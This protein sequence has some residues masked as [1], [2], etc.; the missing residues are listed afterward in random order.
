M[1]G[2]VLVL[3][4]SGKFGCHAAEAFWDRGWLVSQYDRR[5]GDLRSA[6]AKADVIVNG[7]NPPYNAWK[8]DVPAFTDDVIAAAKTSGATVIIPGNIYGYGAGAPEILASDTPKVAR[9]PLGRIR[10]D[11]ERAYRVAGVKTI[12]LRA[13]NFIDTEPSGSWFDKVIVAG[14]AKGQIVAPGPFD[15]PQ[16]W[17][18]LP[19]LATV[20]VDLAERRHR[21]AAFQEVL[22]PGYT[23]T[24]DE[25]RRLLQSVTRRELRLK[26]MNWLPIHL[27]RPFWPL[28]NGL[29]EM[30]YLWSMTHRIDDADMRA[31]LPEFRSTDPL[32]ALTRAIRH[33]D[34]NPRPIGVA[35]HA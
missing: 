4:A 17:A 3:G 19:D 29:L 23:L 5:T 6:A 20:A 21:L 9:N 27:A 11:M 10:N 16:A 30:R 35:T 34:I 7:W 1:T 15:C 18:Y 31:L 2:R 14:L 32:V 13:G 8:T 22:F 28:A 12:V 25:M 33:L 24:F 26:P